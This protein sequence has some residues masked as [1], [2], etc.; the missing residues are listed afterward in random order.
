MSAPPRPQPWLVVVT[1]APGSGKTTLARELA[2][3]LRLP[4]L[5]RDQV[6]GGQLATAGLWRDDVRDPVPREA[7]VGALVD[8]V[9]SLAGHGVTSV[10]EFVVTPGR[11]DAFRR[12]EAAARCLVVVTSAAG[13]Q[14]RADRRDRADP[15][16][17]RP[18]VLAALGH[19]SIE[20][21]LTAPERDEV[22][23]TMQAEFDHPLLPVATDDG[24]DPPITAVVDWIVD[25]TRE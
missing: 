22:R 24:Y 17:R 5:S 25:R 1:G 19:R 23:A 4:F 12:L 3:A 2:S 10:V 16:L 13:A 6:R 8:A 7:A 15:F 9:E 11:V 18:D 20:D 21:Y 14:A